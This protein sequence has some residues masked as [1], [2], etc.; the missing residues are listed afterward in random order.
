LIYVINEVVE[1][2]YLL[3]KR[4][5]A[6]S[7]EGLNTI[8]ERLKLSA[9]NRQGGAEL[10]RNVCKQL[11][12]ARLGAPKYLSKPLHITHKHPKLITSLMRDTQIITPSFECLN[13]SHKAFDGP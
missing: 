1:A 12:P 10:M 11:T 4:M 9:E 8:L 3:L 13:A 6:L 7:V 2:L 5:K